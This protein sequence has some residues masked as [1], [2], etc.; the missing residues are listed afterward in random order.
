MNKRQSKADKAEEYD[1]SVGVRGKY[2]ARYAE[3]TNIAL[4]DTDVVRYFPDSAS[5]NEA[6]R[7]LLRVMGTAGESAAP[8]AKAAGQKRAKL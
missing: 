2:A 8:L 4:L 6:L 3:G 7:L 5:V 1:F